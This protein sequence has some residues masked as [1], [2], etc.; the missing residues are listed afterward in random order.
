MI[1]IITNTLRSKYITSIMLFF[2]YIISNA[3][4]VV[5]YKSDISLSKETDINISIKESFVLGEELD[6]YLTLKS[7]KVQHVFN[8]ETARLDFR[9]IKE[10]FY[11]DVPFDISTYKGG[12]YY[13]SSDAWMTEIWPT[14]QVKIK[15]KENSN[16]IQGFNLNQLFS[17]T[18]LAGKYHLSVCYEGKLFSSASFIIGID[19]E[20]SIPLI[21]KN[22]EKADINERKRK[23]AMFY[24][25]L[26]TGDVWYSKTEESDSIIKANSKKMNI[27]WSEKKEIIVCVNN[28]L[29]NGT[30]TN[31]IIYRSIVPELIRD[32]DK[33]ITLEDKIIARDS[34][35]KLTKQP[36]WKPSIDD[37][38]EDIEQELL[39]VKLWWKE[40]KELIDI[41]NRML[42]PDI[43]EW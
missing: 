35:Y 6:F 30:D 27:F 25:I 33:R 36:E 38:K 11:N 39:K 19:Y 1:F 31:K 37:S 41:V 42:I 40:N 24:S 20:Q 43:F 22:I 2:F 9:L 12:N 15:V 26:I 16:H 14:E 10:P 32:L 8:F 23:Q 18:L 13:I 21:L 17:T 28:N 4:F 7:K 5:D 29:I 34:L 3:Q